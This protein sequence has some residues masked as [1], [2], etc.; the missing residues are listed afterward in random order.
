MADNIE[1][2]P[3]WRVT[4]TSQS[5]DTDIVVRE[6][7]LT[8]IL[9]NKEVATLPCS[10]SHLDY[11]AV[12]FLASEGL[13][14][15]KDDIKKVTVDLSKG[16]VR[17]KTKKDIKP[18]PSQAEKVDSDIK[19]SAPQVFALVEDFIQ[20][21]QLFKDTGGV[22]SAALADTKNILVFSD[23]IGRYNA[24]D[25]VFGECLLND[26]PTTGRLL[27]TSGR[28]SSGIVLKVARRNI[29]LLVSKAAPTNL[30]V[31]LA[32]KLGLTLIG[33]ARDKKMNLYANEWRVKGD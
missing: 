31:R 9:N 1:Q 28:V 4:G 23:D 25:K 30:G 14:N 17:V 6:F 22:H 8:I 2:F 26:I 7:P 19:I 33:F 10:P 29:P 24:I 27:I 3:I 5:I 21:S 20:R 15:S 16:K 12:G 18:A 11:L 13:I 32:Q